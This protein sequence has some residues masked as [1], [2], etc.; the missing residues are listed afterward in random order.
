M[1]VV[2]IKF[3]LAK[4]FYNLYHRTNLAPQ[5]HKLS[6]VALDGDDWNYLGLTEELF[7]D[8]Y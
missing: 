3:S 1:R 7:N 2:P 6:F 4:S 8:L 5:G